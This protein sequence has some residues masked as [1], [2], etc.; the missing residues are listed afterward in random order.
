MMYQQRTRFCVAGQS[1]WQFCGD[2]T[3]W[4]EQPFAKLSA[5]DAMRAYD[6]YIRDWH[7]ADKQR[8]Q[9][10]LYQIVTLAMPQ[11][12]SLGY[13]DDSRIVDSIDVPVD[14]YWPTANDTLANSINFHAKQ[15]RTHSTSPEA[16]NAVNELVR[17]ARYWQRQAHL[18]FKLATGDAF[19]A[20]AW[21]SFDA[22]LAAYAEWQT[23][24]KTTS[25]Q[26]L[27]EDDNNAV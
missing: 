9:L 21:P 18:A 23:V 25:D 5:V 16:D 15:A 8:G 19:D 7:E 1:Y 3:G 2:G 14:G 6:A 10:C 26:L 4:Q 11:R 13:P 17:V 27:R 12:M 22:A 20:F 24:Q